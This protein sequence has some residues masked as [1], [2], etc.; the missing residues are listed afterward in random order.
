MAAQMSSVDPPPSYFERSTATTEPLFHEKAKEKE[1]ESDCPA[2]EP[3]P[4]LKFPVRDRQTKR[5]LRH[6]TRY[7]KKL[8]K[9]APEVDLSSVHNDLTTSLHSIASWE[10]K[11]LSDIKTIKST[12][13][14]DINYA[15]SVRTLASGTKFPRIKRIIEVGEVS[16]EARLNDPR[17]KE[18]RD[19]EK[20]HKKYLKI[21]RE[22]LAREALA[23][24]ER[25]VQAE[26][27]RIKAEMTSVE[28]LTGWIGMLKEKKKKAMG[29]SKK[30]IKKREQ[31]R[32][33]REED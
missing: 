24:K 33:E 16:V 32:K 12:V 7:T 14:A 22:E 13:E 15:A 5:A 28:E 21:K 2:A 17:V 26:R 25:L 31:K 18:I 6:L 23:E 10:V 30:D 3:D 27:D 8:T 4:N 19:R 29:E 20:L 9:S 11:H 1:Y